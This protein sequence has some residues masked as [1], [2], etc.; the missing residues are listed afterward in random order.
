MFPAPL[1]AAL[2]PVT[3]QREI[4]SD[5]IFP[6][7]DTAAITELAGR[8]TAAWNSGHPD[9]VAAEASTY[10]LTA[11]PIYCRRPTAT[12]QPPCR[13]EYSWCATAPPP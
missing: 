5:P 10:P 4:G 9:R 8:Y 2:K 13:P 3:A 11:Q 1:S 6:T 7:M 12:D